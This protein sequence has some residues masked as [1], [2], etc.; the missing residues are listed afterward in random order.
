MAQLSRPERGVRIRA[1]QQL[2]QAKDQDTAQ[3]LSSVLEH[4][5]DRV[6]RGNAAAALGEIKGGSAVTLLARALEDEAVSVRLNAVRALGKIG[7]EEAV[8]ILG[9]ILL[10]HPDR[11]LRWL[12]ARTLGEQRCEGSRRFLEEAALDSDHTVRKEVDQSLAQW[13]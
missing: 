9:D 6:V 7:S 8:E 11:R 13:Q 12:A 5:E 4:D 2:A 1:V 10:D 3:L